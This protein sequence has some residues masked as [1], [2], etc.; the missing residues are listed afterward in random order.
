MPRHLLGDPAD[1][2][3]SR[4]NF[5]YDALDDPPTLPK[6]YVEALEFGRRIV[7]YARSKDRARLTLDC[8]YIALGDAEIEGV[9]MTE[10]SAR[11][12]VTKAAISKRVREIREDL[13]LPR[14]G[15]NKT[16]HACET[17][18]TTNISRVALGQS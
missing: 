18:R 10:M 15:F 5:D 9:S 1:S 14:T 7:S 2:P 13:H 17:Y 16:E 8:L 3:N 4:V 12:G 11:H 6:G